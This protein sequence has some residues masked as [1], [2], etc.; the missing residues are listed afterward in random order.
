MTPVGMGKST[1]GVDLASVDDLDELLVASWMRQAAEMP[2]FGG[3]SDDADL[4]PHAPP[5]STAVRPPGIT[6]LSDDIERAVATFEAAEGKGCRP[7]RIH[8]PDER[9]D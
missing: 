1:R 6:F 8:D 7:V 9:I 3:R 5:F 2:F 4:D